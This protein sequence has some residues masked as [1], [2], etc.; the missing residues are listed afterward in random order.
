[1]DRYYYRWLVNIVSV[2]VDIPNPDNYSNVLTI[3]YLT[4]FTWT[5]MM[6]GNR[7][8]DGISLRGQYYSE[9]GR[10]RDDN[11]PCS[12][13]EMMVALAKRCETHIMSDPSYGDRTGDWFWLMIYNLGLSELDD[14][15]YDDD[16]AHFIIRRLLDRK[17][18]RNGEGGLFTVHNGKDLRKV[19]IWYQLN[20]YLNENLF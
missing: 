12:V 15:H 4:D 20:W 19:E 2:G 9:T 17:Y 14:L 8:S 6:D 16:Q 11:R 7:A 5:M 10:Q 3:L 1:M 18:K 13:L